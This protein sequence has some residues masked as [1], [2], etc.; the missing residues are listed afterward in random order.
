MKRSLV[1]IVFAFVIAILV[2]C[3]GAG[4]APT[5]PNVDQPGGGIDNAPDL[6]GAAQAETQSSGHAL[7]G[8]WDVLV[9]AEDE[10]I[11]FVPLRTSSYHFNMAPV[12]DSAMALGLTE[13]PQIISGVLYANVKLT[14][15]FPA[16]LNLSGFD[17]KGIVITEG[18]KTGFADTGIKIAGPTESRLLNAD[19]FTRWWNPAEFTH[20]GITGYNQG[21][22]GT[23]INPANAATLNGYKLFAD[24][25]GVDESMST[26]DPE[27]RAFFQAGS[28]NSRHYEISLAGGFKFN[29]AVDC[30]WAA[31]T[32]NPPV[33]LPDDFPIE[34]N[35]NEPYYFEVSEPVNTLWYDG[36]FH[37]GN[38]FYDITVYSWKDIADF[39][40][41]TVEAP[42]SFTDSSDT[43]DSTTANS[44]TYHFEFIIPDLSSA[45]PLDTLFSMQVPGSY[46]TALTGVDKPL[47][48]YHRHLTSVS[49]EN[50]V[51]NT[52]PVAIM[53]A[54]SG[55]DI[56]T[57][58]TVS[59]DA[60]DSYD[61]DGFITQYLWDFNADGVYT[62]TFQGGQETPTHTFNDAGTFNVKVKV[63]DNS[64]G[65]T[66][67]DPVIVNVTLEVNDPPVAVAEAT[68]PTHILEDES[69]SFDGAASYDPD[70][71][72]VDWQWDFNGDGT[73]GDA[74]SGGMTTPTA[75][76]PNPGTFN[77][78][79]KVVDNEGG[80]G[81]LATPIQVIADDVPNVPPI[82]SAIAVTS[83]DIN[84]CGTVE[85]DASGS[86][87]ADGILA[88]YLWDFNGDGTFGDLYDSGDNIHPVKD[89]PNSGSFDV[90]LKVVDDESG[91]DTLDA[92]ITVNVTNLGPTADA[93][94]ST[95][96]DIENYDSVTFD[97]SNSVDP[98]C[99]V[100]VQY[101]WDFD[102][103]GSYG[104]AY[105]SGDDVN[106][107]KQYIGVD[108]YEVYLKVIDNNGAEDDTDIPIV[109]TVS[110]ALPT[111]CAEITSEY[112]Y[113]WETEIYFSGACSDDLDGNIVSWEWDLE[114]DGS[115][116][117]TG[118]TASYYFG[119]MA[120]HTMQLRVTD[121]EGGQNLLVTPLSFNIW[122]DS[123]QPPE[124][125]AV[126]HS[127]TTSQR[128]NNNESV[129]LSVDFTD[130]APPGDT[131]TYLWS[132]PYGS[133][134]DAT[135]ATPTWY[136]PTTTPNPTHFNITVEVMDAMGMT[137]TGTCTQWVTQWPVFTNNPNAV[138]GSIIPSQ[139]LKDI[140]TE[141]MVD[142][143]DFKFPDVS[144]DGNVVYI[145]WWATWCGWCIVEMPLV[146][147]L[148]QMYSGPGYV[149]LHIDLDELE[150]DAE[151]WIVAHPEYHA[152]YWLLDTGPVYFYKL[153]PWNSNLTGI[154]Q[155][156][157]FDRD[158]RLRG[159]Q[160]GSIVNL[161]I[162]PIDKY[163]RELV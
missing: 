102:G 146:D 33:N 159:L 17:V 53:V 88:Q 148:Y 20:T 135:S 5:S 70:G 104:D 81:I 45:L 74:C 69:V 34:A 91:E 71:T 16:K 40:P 18:S 145:N 48:G 108:V 111:A 118:E 162:E 44:A 114:A 36:G 89:F 149:Q 52:P 47:C 94:A 82:A 80:V 101:L 39:G 76:F 163:L 1:L 78:K 150:S 63:R 23:S 109:V 59:F 122:D 37:A 121:N 129:S 139:D 50:P 143:A 98:D 130:P 46:N 132:A 90:Q 66:V 124:V 10:T 95:S 49:D 38:V 11:E 103:D 117:A 73:Y 15:P 14:H 120:A 86:F 7:L 68:S 65:S 9:N 147:E 58:Q 92:P 155:H 100:P 54:T 96:T 151:P 72:V 51:F 8:Y 113:Y 22:L 99:G 61:P 106:P 112:P 13:P 26:L 131:H 19:G 62:D 57:G 160:Y 6:T 116:E 153:V 2:G 79:L 125:T 158:G 4:V 24:G 56:L 60:S 156:Y 43:P 152:D 161:G 84:A 110:N 12:L 115:Y 134:D 123:N 93:V 127:R 138:E 85:F 77:V 105:D 119:A 64:T 29:Y 126:N 3:A 42:G 35:Q 75:L 154:P 67:S 32:V 87:D 144:P 140:L 28:V 142:P 27:S 133:F 30:S 31:P 21:K 55:T 25:F 97:A 137:D 136:P 128:N 141:L 107:T 41:L 157:V 83:T